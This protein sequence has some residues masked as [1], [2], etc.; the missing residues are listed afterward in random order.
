LTE[1]TGRP[2]AVS[3]AYLAFARDEGDFRG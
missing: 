3:C 1:S 2:F